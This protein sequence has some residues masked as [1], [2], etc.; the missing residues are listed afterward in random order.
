M[1]NGIMFYGVANSGHAGHSLWLNE[2]TEILPST[3]EHAS[4]SYWRFGGKKRGLLLPWASLDAALCP[5]I[6]DGSGL[7]LPGEQ[8]QGL[9]AVH[10]LLGWSCVAW[11][12]R[13]ADPRMNSNA[14]LIRLGEHS[15]IELFAAGRR[16]F[17]GFMGRMKYDLSPGSYRSPAVGR[18]DLVQVRLSR[19]QTITLP[20]KTTEKKQT[21]GKMYD[22]PA[23]VLHLAP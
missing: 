13:S 22:D 16:R 10:R 14:A 21:G 12:D 5:G 18:R 11:W 15:P 17:P 6:R 4:G 23:A 8:V 1:S 7:A 19:V 20:T 3:H 2:K 9:Y